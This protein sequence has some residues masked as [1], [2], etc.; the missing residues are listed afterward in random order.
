MRASGW[1]AWLGLWF[2]FSLL[3]GVEALAQTPPKECRITWGGKTW[4]AFK[5]S[6]G[7]ATG[8]DPGNQ[9]VDVLVAAAPKGV[10]PEARLH[11]DAY[12][13]DMSVDGGGTAPS[14]HEFGLGAAVPIKPGQ[15]SVTVRFKDPKRPTAPSTSWTLNFT[16]WVYTIGPWGQLE[17]PPFPGN[18]KEEWIYPELVDAAGNF[19]ARLGA[20]QPD[21]KSV[22]GLARYAP[23]GKLTL[24][25]I[26]PTGPWSEIEPFRKL[27]AADK[28]GNLYVEHSGNI[29][30]FSPS[31][32]FLRSLGALGMGIPVKSVQDLDPWA[33]RQYPP[34]P[35]KS[36]LSAVSGFPYGEST[37][38]IVDGAVHLL[39]YAAETA[40]RDKQKVLL[41]RFTLDG[42]LEVLATVAG[43]GTK[44]EG[45]WTLAASPDGNLHFPVQASGKTVLLTYSKQGAFVRET[46]SFPSGLERLKGIDSEGAFYGDQ[47]SRVSKDFSLRGMRL[48]DLRYRY[49]ERKSINEPQVE[50]DL[51]TNAEAPKGAKGTPHCW[52]DRDVVYVLHPDRQVAKF[53]LQG[54]AP[55]PAQQ[56]LPSM[57]TLS[58]R[59]GPEDRVVLDG[60]KRVNLEACLK[61]PKGDPMP[62]V[63]VTF[64]A[65]DKDLPKR[66]RIEYP[67]GSSRTTDTKGC[68]TGFYLPPLVRDKDLGQQG[69][70]TLED[71][72]RPLI[73]AFEARAV[74]KGQA[75]L[76]ASANATAFPLLDALFKIS[77]RGYA[78]VEKIPA[79]IPSLRGGIATGTAVHKPQGTGQGGGTAQTFGFP[80][81]GATVELM[82]LDGKPLGSAATDANGSF[83]IDFR[84]EGGASRPNKLLGDEL[85]FTQYEPE[86][87]NQ[88]SRTRVAL[89]A[90]EAGTISGSQEQ[91]GYQTGGL[92]AL[93]D[94]HFPM[95]LA[96]AAKD[97]AIDMELD[98]LERVGLLV[99]S[100]RA[101]HDLTQHAA[102][103]FSDSLGD[104]VEGISGILL[105]KFNPLGAKAQLG[106]K[107]YRL[108]EQVGGVAASATGAGA[109]KGEL[110]TPMR[111]KTA[112]FV[113]GKLSAGLTSK[114]GQDAL[115]AGYEIAAW[116]K[117]KN[118]LAET[119]ANGNEGWKGGLARLLTTPCRDL[120]QAELDRARDLWARDAI[121]Y[122]GSPIGPIVRERYAEI[123]AHKQAVADQQL[124]WDLFKTNVRQG[125][126]LLQKSATVIAAATT[127]PV[128]AQEMSEGLGKLQTALEAFGAAA[129]AYQGYQWWKDWSTGMR[130]MRQFGET[131]LG[132]AVGETALRAP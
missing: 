103:R 36:S 67:E 131:A 65:N 14:G 47:C 82:D 123:A 16:A 3:V 126:D 92:R 28:D 31:G 46:S 32:N 50:I 35:P 20:R 118:F 109:A 43:P 89:R 110:L 83:T 59:L 49:R 5:A 52:V 122:T 42:K 107:E 40:G 87:E 75:P 80:V 129:D 77:R 44:Y 2:L 106:A 18:P 58:I 17:R 13:Y 100:L 108:G 56:A 96:A 124:E 93:L 116:E 22:V 53:T 72:R 117:A 33:P 69:G 26:T 27:I 55:A 88:V 63:E 102:T 104:M 71:R 25:Q 10:T 127:G 54:G 130:A 70:L 6:G 119:L 73:I 95:R 68:A 57:P 97:Q 29:V 111:W 86:V 4:L 38:A 9:Q 61:D 62:G 81:A 21:N 91:Y 41:V 39:G 94:D 115:T 12:G 23:G 19:Y 79:L 8:R 120:G 64:S 51:L 37:S 11:C 125:L 76:E 84:T 132:P 60:A 99:V 66:G 7:V 85:V 114:V 113:V 1:S 112:H 24:Y 15:N 74:L 34:N 78:T 121:P 45:G 105:D 128:A 98:R 101:T 90:M 30:L 48:E